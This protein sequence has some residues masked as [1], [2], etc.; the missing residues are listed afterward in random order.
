MK[1]KPCPECNGSNSV[2]D[3]P[4]LKNILVCYIC[5]GTGT[6]PDEP[7]SHCQGCGEP[8]E[9]GHEWCNL[10]RPA[11]DLW[12]AAQQEEAHYYGSDRTM[13]DPRS[14]TPSDSHSEPDHP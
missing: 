6:I 13:E 11:A 12:Q 4:G 8:V 14:V 1:M 5:E 3:I 10:H 7:V 2:I 9:L